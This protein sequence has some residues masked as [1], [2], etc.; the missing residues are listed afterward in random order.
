[1]SAARSATFVQNSVVVGAIRS[2]A[3]SPIATRVDATLAI[4]C[5]DVF[6]SVIMKKRKMSTS[7][8][9]TSTRQNS[10]PVIGPRCQRAVISWPAA[11]ITPIPIANVTQNVTAIASRWSRSRIVKTPTTMIPSASTIHGGHR[12]PPEGERIGPRRP[13]QEEAEN[14]RRSSTG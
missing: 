12:P 10:K 11:A 9:K 4:S 13:E 3:R 7:G 1:M 2:T 8:E 6:G 14:E 5:G